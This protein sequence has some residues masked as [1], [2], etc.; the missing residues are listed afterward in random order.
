M[1]LQRPEAVAINLEPKRIST[2]LRY[3]I[4]SYYNN[5]LDEK[6]I[7][8]NENDAIK[9]ALEKVQEMSQHHL[10]PATESFD[11]D[12]DLHQACLKQSKALVVAL[13]KYKQNN[14]D[15][16]L[17]AYKEQLDDFNILVEFADHT[18]ENNTYSRLLLVLGS[19]LA[20]GYA[21][22]YP[23]LALSAVINTCIT[24]AVFTA[25]ASYGIIFL[26][27]GMILGLSSMGGAIALSLGV[28]MVL[29]YFNPSQQGSK[30]LV[31]AMR[32]LSTACEEQ[33][34]NPTP[35]IPSNDG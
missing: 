3:R 2:Q 14:A 15:E 13:L 10:H 4:W 9:L 6:T 12:R 34:P 30:V 28:G 11:Y 7:T 25:F 29:N 26:P 1:P 17:T 35:L 21:C 23:S 5:N 31:A 32:E 16:N 22:A 33:I 19:I 27:L 8:N 18:N 20:I 24:A